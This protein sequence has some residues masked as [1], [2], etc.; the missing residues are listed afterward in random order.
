VTNKGL[1][2]LAAF[3]PGTGVTLDLYLCGVYSRQPDVAAGPDRASTAVGL[4]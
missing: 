2:F 3:D 4:S 1:P